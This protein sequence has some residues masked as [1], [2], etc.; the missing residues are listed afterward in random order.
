MPEIS[1]DKLVSFLSYYPILSQIEEKKKELESCSLSS[2]EAAALSNEDEILSA[3][4]EINEK[5]SSLKS[6]S[7]LIKE[8]EKTRDSFTS[9]SDKLQKLLIFYNETL[10]EFTSQYLSTL[11]GL[12]TNIYQSLYQDPS[13]SV[14]LSVEDSRGK[15]VISLYVDRLYNG[16]TYSEELSDASGS[17]KCMMGLMIDLYYILVT[18]QPRIMFIDEVFEYLHDDVLGRTLNF[19]QSF[20]DNFGFSFLIIDHRYSVV[21]KYASSIYTVENGEVSLL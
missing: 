19:L 21:K 10:E 15:K 1:F 18:N 7:L 3:Q 5:E 20:V 14:R 8:T 9:L 13:K 17:E 11:S 16:Q 4:A 12:L 6:L 2:G